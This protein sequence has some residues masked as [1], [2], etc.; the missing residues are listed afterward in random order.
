MQ[1]NIFL[2]HAD[3]DKELATTISRLLNKVSLGQIT[4]WYS[5]D[6]RPDTGILPGDFWFNTI[7]KS[8]SEAT[9]TIVLL[10]PNS[11]SRPW[12]YYEGGVAQSSVNCKKVMPICIGVS[13]DSIKPPMQ[14]YELYQASDYS[15]LAE[16]IGKLLYLLNVFFDEQLCKPELIKCI[17]Y[18]ND[19]KFKDNTCHNNT[20]NLLIDDIKKYIDTNARFIISQIQQSNIKHDSISKDSYSIPIDTPDNTGTYIVIKNDDMVKDVLDNIYYLINKYV[21]AF[22]YMQSWILQEKRTKKYLAIYYSISHLIPAHNLFQPTFH[23]QIK[24]LNKP[25]RETTKDESTIWNYNYEQ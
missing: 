4:V 5:S 3:A 20:N 23:W 7:L 19:F 10:T 9:I 6:S 2:S 14:M 11:I 22:T 1:H 16:F 13:K 21:E 25:Y 24:L 8:I 17:S 18:I 12:I 15:S